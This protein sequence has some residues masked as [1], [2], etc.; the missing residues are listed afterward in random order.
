ML[1][2]TISDA[3]G[4]LHARQK[5]EEDNQG[6]GSHALEESALSA[7]CLPTNFR[8]AEGCRNALSAFARMIKCSAP[9]LGRPRACVNNAPSS[10][11]LGFFKKEGKIQDWNISTTHRLPPLLC[12]TFN[13]DDQIGIREHSPPCAGALPFPP[14]HGC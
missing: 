14:V 6:A 4:E 13:A 5:E 3:V 8:S 1:I 2:N 9:P 7:P 11:P 12:G 10:E